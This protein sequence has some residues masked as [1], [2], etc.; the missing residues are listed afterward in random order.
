MMQMQ[1][2]HTFA[3]FAM[4]LCSKNAAKLCHITLRT[5]QRAPVTHGILG[6]CLL[7]IKKCKTYFRGSVKKSSC[8][9][10]MASTILLM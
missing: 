1:S 2:K 6:K 4:R 7:G 8:M 10:N 5:N 9:M 3:L